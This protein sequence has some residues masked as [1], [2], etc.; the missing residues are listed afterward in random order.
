M[1]LEDLTREKKVK[2]KEINKGKTPFDCASMAEIEMPIS[3]EIHPS[4]II[5]ATPVNIKTAS[6]MPKV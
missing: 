5:G 3:I 2:V 1:N 4:R 6:V